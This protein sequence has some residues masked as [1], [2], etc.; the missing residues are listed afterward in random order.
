M[1][2][3][4][5]M[6]KLTDTMEEGV[7]LAWKK[8]EGDRVQAGEV[9]AEIETDKAVMD[10]E[11]FAPGVLR[12]LLV[13]DGETVQSGKLIAVIAEADEDIASALSDGVTAVP[14]VGS[15]PK[16]APPAGTAALA[17]P[18]RQQG[19]RVL[20]SPRAKALAAERG[21][22]L[23][24][25]T[26]TGPG[27]RIVEDDVAAASAPPSQGLPAGADEPLSQMRKAIARST[28]QSKA[29]VPHFYLTVDIDMEQAERVRDE[30]KQSRQPHP[31][32][33]DV[34]IKAAALA[35]K[36]HPEI[37]VSFTGEAIRRY[38]QIDIGVAVGMEDGLIT[39]VIRNCGGK[40][41]A[42]ISGETKQLIERAR[43]K[44]LSPQEYTGATFAI[45]NL[46]MFDVDQFIALLMPPQAASIAVGAIRDVPVVSKGSVVAGRRM[47]VTL[48][49][50]HR[51]LDGLMGAQF[52]KEFKRVLEHPQEL[53][54]PVV[55]P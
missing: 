44:R 15:A 3:R 47:K 49:C 1:A 51:A 30:F 6:P 10:L 14:S 37:N 52:L 29:P 40:T 35:L 23:S 17:Q 13:Q 9:I 36:R 7:L 25:L 28:V 45:S 12:K 22:E 50:D 39:P 38:A 41:L 11:A 27:G 31:S 54:S 53:L 55:T 19:E 48:S 46:G 26:G 4:V 20:A 16:P 18:G 24:T 33:T 2:S 21:V 8:H 43:Q 32:I 34:L 42:E 5:V